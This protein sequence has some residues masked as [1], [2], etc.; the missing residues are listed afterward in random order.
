MSETL[1]FLCKKCGC[2]H[3]TLDEF[4]DEQVTEDNNIVKVI[5]PDCGYDPK[6]SF[7]VEESK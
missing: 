1:A 6:L 2:G 5:C 3:K 7:T 4:I